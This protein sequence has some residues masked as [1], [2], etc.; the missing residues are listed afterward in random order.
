MF[1]CAGEGGAPD[2]GGGDDGQGHND[3]DDDDGGGPG[4]GGDRDHG[5][6]RPRPPCGGNDADGGPSSGLDGSG[7]GPSSS[8]SR[9]TQGAVDNTALMRQ[10]LSSCLK[11][12]SYITVK[13]PSDDQGFTLKPLQILN[14]HTRNIIVKTWETQ[15]QSEAPKGNETVTGIFNATVQPFVVQERSMQHQLAADASEFDAFIVEDP[16]VIDI[17]S[18]VGVGPD[19]RDMLRVWTVG[20]LAAVEGCLHFHDPMKLTPNV[21]VGHKDYPV[22]CLLDA[23]RDSGFTGKSA[24]VTHK[25]RGPKHFDARSQ[26]CKGFYYKCLL[27]LPRLWSEGANPFP[28]NLS[29]AFYKLLLAK[30]AAALPSLSA[31][32]CNAEYAKL[33]GGE[34]PLR[35]ALD[36]VKPE[37]KKSPSPPKFEIDGGE[38]EAPPASPEQKE[39]NS[40]TQRQRPSVGVVEPTEPGL[41]PGRPVI[42]LAGGNEE[43]AS[44]ERSAGSAGP[45]HAVEWPEGIPRTIYGQ[46]ICY[47]AAVPQ[48]YNARI[49]VQCNNPAH[50]D[51]S[52]S[53]SLA[54][55]ANEYGP[56][57]A[58]MF[59]GAWLK[60]SFHLDAYGHSEFKPSR[61]DIHA[62]QAEFP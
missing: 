29:Q 14:L 59:L 11:V 49:R 13:V 28:S 30:P 41:P 24:T 26:P 60:H 62:Y 3:N 43:S 55:C 54:L 42:E 22:L 57:A 7:G 38:E 50:G 1:S 48:R 15:I 40:T 5:L 34:K 12:H 8:G 46:T 6:R 23:L 32:E 44:I 52:R 20:A 45:R 25:R 36:A 19:A 61:A 10:W 39:Q 37:P 56:R 53:R 58:E 4:P 21:A 47:E 27:E 16:K 33:T 18:L 2:D 31:A 17:L 9:P 51:C 35:L